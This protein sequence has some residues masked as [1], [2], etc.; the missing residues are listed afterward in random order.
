MKTGTD[1]SIRVAEEK[2]PARFLVIYTIKDNKLRQRLDIYA[3]DEL[4]D[5]WDAR[6]AH[7]FIWG[8]FT[9]LI[10]EEQWRY[11]A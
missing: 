2:I 11:V 7:E 6:A 4:K 8:Y 1:T 3:P 9:A 5:E 10:P